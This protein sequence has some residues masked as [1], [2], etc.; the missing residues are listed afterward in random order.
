MIGHFNFDFIMLNYFSVR[1]AAVWQEINLPKFVYKAFDVLHAGKMNY[2]NLKRVLQRIVRGQ[3]D[4][5]E[6][7]DNKLLTMVSPSEKNVLLYA[8]SLESSDPEIFLSAI[9]FEHLIEKFTDQISDV[10]IKDFIKISD[11]GMASK[12]FEAKAGQILTNLILLRK[13]LLNYLES[14][15]QSN[16]NPISKRDQNYFGFLYGPLVYYINH[17]MYLQGVEIIGFLIFYRLLKTESKEIS[18][19]SKLESFK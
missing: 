9:K 12:Q 1:R 3:S 11:L 18:N 15:S 2:F 14:S 6:R 19:K 16:S 4:F 13:A 7:L 17:L 5:W 8:G 10:R